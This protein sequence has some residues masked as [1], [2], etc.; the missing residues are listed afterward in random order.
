MCVLVSSIQKSKLKII[1]L[2]YIIYITL[3][4]QE[5]FIVARRLLDLRAT[6]TYRTQS[7]QIRKQR[8]QNE[9]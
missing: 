5:I 9:N 8:R 6:R 4:A 3:K 2:F 1:C 7:E